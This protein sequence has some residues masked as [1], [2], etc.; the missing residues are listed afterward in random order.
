MKTK[1]NLKSVD[2]CADALAREISTRRIFDIEEVK[3]L[4]AVRIKSAL[5]DI[6]D[7]NS[8]NVQNEYDRLLAQSRKVKLGSPEYIM[9][10]YE[11]ARAKAALK[12]SNR[13]LNHIRKDQ[14]NESLRAFVLEKYGES[15]LDGF[16]ETG[17]VHAD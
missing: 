8:I 3:T 6:L 10:G 12:K 4:I 16:V 2:H 13:L 1:I 15:A 7:E 5:P 14:A 17:A 9:L 11:L